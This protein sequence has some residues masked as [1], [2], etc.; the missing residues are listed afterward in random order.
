MSEI[1]LDFDRSQLLR[2]E[3]VASEDFPAPADKN[4]LRF[5]VHDQ[6]DYGGSVVFRTIIEEPVDIAGLFSG[7]S[8]IATAVVSR[9][10]ELNDIGE[11]VPQ[12]A[13]EVAKLKK[14][15]SE[16][17]ALMQGLENQTQQTGKAKKYGRTVKLYLPQAIQI[18]DGVTFENQ[19][20][21]VI[22]AGVEAGLKQGQGAASS[23][24]KGISEGV[25]SFVESMKGA[26]ST[27]A[28]RLAVTR[29]SEKLGSDVGNA[30]KSVSRT[31][32]N[33]NTRALFRSVNLRNFNFT[34]KMIPQSA[35]EALAIK[36]IIKH[37]RTELYP[38]EIRVG[39]EGDGLNNVS[40]GYKFP[41]KFEIVFEYKGKQVATKVLPS[42]LV[43]F[44]ATYNGTSMGMHS[45]GNFQEVE[46]SMNFAEARAL[47]RKDIEFGG[48]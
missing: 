40:L 32:L 44:T 42:Y 29:A 1:T 21:G 39:D 27:D 14:E 36:E 8:D 37:F 5:P 16:A 11:K 10:Q 24:A 48:Y 13:E 38:D 20:L 34:F 2:G 45:D 30:V 23:V 7:F 6:G 33:P 41:N 28:A 35:K 19:D 31:T 47:N 43:S 18:T 25:G 3:K 46:I 9:T 17:N 22:G 15:L 4:I 12:N 26:A